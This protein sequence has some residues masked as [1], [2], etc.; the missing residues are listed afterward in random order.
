M[1]VLIAI[2]SRGLIGCEVVYALCKLAAQGFQ[3]II[4]QSSYGVE[5]ARRKLLKEFLDS[6]ADYLLFLDDDIVPP[7]DIVSSLA[8]YRRDFVSAEY[9]IWDYGEVF[10]SASRKKEKSPSYQRV[11][12]DELDGLQ[13]VDAC[14]L[15]ACLI[16]KA[17]ARKAFSKD[18]FSIEYDDSGEVIKGED[19]KFCECAKNLGYKIYVDF[20]VVCKHYKNR[21]IVI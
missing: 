2:P 4:S 18:C 15:G 1:K 8:R 10:S 7:A 21:S 13:E 5:A 6:G 14:G 19:Y 9:P 16:S 17:L 3:V 20:N 11:G 12:L